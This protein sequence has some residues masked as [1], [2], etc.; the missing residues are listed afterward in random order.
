MKKERINWKDR[1]IKAETQI[2][3]S[4]KYQDLQKENKFTKFLKTIVPILTVIIIGLQTCLMKSQ[5]KSIQNQTDLIESQDKKIQAQLYLTESEQRSAYINVCGEV[6]ND[7]K[8]ELQKQTKSKAKYL[9]D[10]LASQIV[11]LSYTL[12]PYI[13]SGTNAESLN[14]EKTLKRLSPEKGFIL[15]Y[16]LKSKI[17]SQFIVENIFKKSNFS[18][19]ELRRID[20]SNSILNE[21]NLFRS[22]LYNTTLN[23]SKL[24][25]CKLKEA[26]LRNAKL[27]NCNLDSAILSNSRLGNADIRRSSLICARLNKVKGRLLNLSKSDL[28]KARFVRAELMG[29]NLKY[30]DLR[31]AHFLG[32]NLKS[33][34]TK[35]GIKFT[36]IDSIKVDVYNWFE[37]LKKAN[38]LGVDELKNRYYVENKRFED[39][40]GKYY[41]VIRKKASVVIEASH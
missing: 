35:K 26:D 20:L 36:E 19:T 5:D 21:A 24:R 17:D 30:S 29:A 34:L 33:T 32:T 11:T 2:K 28:R 37:M 10:E 15:T 13:I 8:V 23:H 6:V 9:S 14:D 31:E 39:N 4:T 7:I 40:F 3:I 1:A 25:S 12:K 18:N 38:V 27:Q 41:Y 22:S 16:L